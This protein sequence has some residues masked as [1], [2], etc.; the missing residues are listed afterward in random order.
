MNLKLIVITFSLIPVLLNGIEISKIKDFEIDIKSTQQTT[1]FSLKAKSS[2]SKDIES[3]FE[4]VIGIVKNSDI[5][6]GGKYNIYPNYNY[7]ENRKI[8]NGYNSNIHFKCEF[9]DIKYYEKLLSEVKHFNLPLSQGKINYKSSLEV[10]EK[11]DAKLEL[12]AYTYAKNYTKYLNKQFKNCNIKNIDFTNKI[13]NS[14]IP[15]RSLSSTSNS[16]IVTAPIGDKL[17][18]KISVNYVFICQNY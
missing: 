16:T 2:K 5:C 14:P 12:K 7:V 4:K 18:L 8:I 9:D 6:V 15:Y 3:K 1:N 13:S 11:G 17:K 10:K